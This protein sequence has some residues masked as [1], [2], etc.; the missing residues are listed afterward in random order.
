MKANVVLYNHESTKGLEDYLHYL[1]RILKQ[2]NIKYDYSSILIDP[3]IKA[4]F[5]FVFEACR[6]PSTY[7]ELKNLK[8]PK[9]LIVTEYLNSFLG[10]K[11]LNMFSIYDSLISTIFKLFLPKL[12]FTSVSFKKWKKF[13]FSS[14]FVLL[15]IICPIL[16]TISLIN[17][18]ILPLK[19]E[20]KLFK[21]L[22]RALSNFKSI[23]LIDFRFNLEKRYNGLLNNY[24]QFEL[25]VGVSEAFVKGYKQWGKTCVVSPVIYE[26]DI[27]LKVLENC[28]VD[29]LF[30][31]EKPIEFFSGSLTPFRKY[32]SSFLENKKISICQINENVVKFLDSAP[33]NNI[34]SC[35]SG[36]YQVFGKNLPIYEL[37]IPQ[38]DTWLYSSP[39]RTYRT[40][41][42]G[43]IPTSLLKSYPKDDSLIAS[44]MI[45]CKANENIFGY[46]TL[47]LIR[48]DY[49][50][51]KNLLKGYKAKINN[52]LI[53]LED[54]MK[55]L[56]I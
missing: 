45:N 43:R 8:I 19:F 41:R 33:S 49:K 50:I 25:Y 1:E 23:I 6:A 55:N 28:F 5:A 9:I 2:L 24:D 18:T 42:Y 15:N 21:L 54:C 13:Y 12:S 22:K 27:D 46:Y 48:S 29:L 34:Y 20:K 30:N 26:S 32:V 52:E 44:L 36:A 37:Y 7:K 4:D 31:K 47:D 56:L 16:Y 3:N 51:F 17:R 11:G 40:I 35:I 14:N 39:M 38:S 10:F 53:Y